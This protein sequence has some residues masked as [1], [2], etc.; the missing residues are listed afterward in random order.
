MLDEHGGWY[1]DF[2][3]GDETFVIFAGRVFRYR[4]GDEA[5]RERARAHGRAVGVPV[6][7]L[8]WER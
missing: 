4:R 6:R 3:R 7:Q 8:D 1:T 5:G 2:T